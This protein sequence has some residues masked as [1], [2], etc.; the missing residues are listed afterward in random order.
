MN[1]CPSFFAFLC[2][3]EIAGYVASALVLTA[4]CMREM[5]PLRMVSLFSNLAFIAYGVALG[6]TPVWVLHALLLA[7][8]GWRLAQAMIIRAGAPG[9]KRQRLRAALVASV[10]AAACLTLGSPAGHTDARDWL[11]VRIIVAS[12]GG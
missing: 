9:P 11:G 12:A 2:T 7:M 3:W 4:F 1:L 6:L 10:V 8:N 5:I